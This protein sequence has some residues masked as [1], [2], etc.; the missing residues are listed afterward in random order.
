M[1]TAF[2]IVIG[3][4][5]SGIFNILYDTV[6]QCCDNIWWISRLDC[7]KDQRLMSLLLVLDTL[8]LNLVVRILFYVR[9]VWR[10]ATQ[11]E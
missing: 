3:G 10:Q 7:L 5:N 9:F 8:S 6:D 1:N 4:L 11:Q 2:K